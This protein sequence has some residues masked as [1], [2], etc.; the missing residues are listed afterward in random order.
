MSFKHHGPFYI[1]KETIDNEKKYEYL[2][3]I[4]KRCNGN[5][6]DERSEAK[7]IVSDHPLKSDVSAKKPI[8][9]ISTYIFDSAMQGKM[10]HTAKYVPKTNKN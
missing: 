8:I 3:E 9:V 5:L 2:C 1:N 10:I 4:I 6:I 7:I